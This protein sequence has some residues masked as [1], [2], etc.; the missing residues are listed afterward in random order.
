MR[1]NYV[2]LLKARLSV[3]K[4]LT[5]ESH[6]TSTQVRRFSSFVIVPIMKKCDMY[7]NAIL[8]AQP[9]YSVRVEKKERNTEHRGEY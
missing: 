3:L 4:N 7:L 2:K 1:I 6:R 5:T 9:M 8:S